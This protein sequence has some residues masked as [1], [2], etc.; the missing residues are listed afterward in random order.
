M[1]RAKQANSRRRFM[2]Q[3]VLGAGATAATLGAGTVGLAAAEEDIAPIRVPDEFETAKSAPF[4]AVAG[5]GML[6]IS[7]FIATSR[8]SAPTPPCPRSTPSVV[9]VA[10]CSRP[11]SPLASAIPTSSTLS[12]TRSRCSLAAGKQQSNIQCSELHMP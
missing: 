10:P 11:P 3:A 6:P 8:S 12:V 2:K 9:A 4:P 1:S 5:S 7:H